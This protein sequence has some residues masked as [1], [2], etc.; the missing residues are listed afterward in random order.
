MPA[1]TLS[2]PVQGQVVTVSAAV[3]GKAMMRVFPTGV[4]MNRALL[5][6]PT[7]A[8]CVPHGRGDEPSLLLCL[9]NP[10]TC[11]PRAWG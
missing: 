5:P 10:V 2:R 7:M 4:G 3:R 1:I 9:V 6:L 11:S 8:Q